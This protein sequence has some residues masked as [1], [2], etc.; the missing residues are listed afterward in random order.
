MAIRNLFYSG[1]YRKVLADAKTS[2]TKDADFFTYRSLIALGNDEQV[3]KAIPSN[4]IAELLALKMY[5]SF[6]MASDENKD[7]ILEKLKD[8]KEW[9]SESTTTA[10]LQLILSIIH[11]ESKNYKEALRFIHKNHENLELL[12]MTVQIYLKIDRVDLAEKQVKAMQDVDDDDVLT[13]L[14]SAWV[15]AARGGDKVQE[16]FHSLEELVEKFGPSVVLLNTMAAC[17][18]ALKNYNGAFGHLKQARELALSNKDKVPADTLINSA[19]CLQHLNKAPE[20]IVRIIG[21]LKQ[22]YPTHP[23]IVRRNAMESI[24]DKQAVQY[25]TGPA[26]VSKK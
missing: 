6:R 26:A 9:N 19:I 25:A 7:L 20:L 17:E 2:G 18:I 11:F 10:S 14:A 23:W 13:T 3:I 15:S 22:S 5:A 12:A 24:F 21:E 8:T 16:G 1:H 4:A